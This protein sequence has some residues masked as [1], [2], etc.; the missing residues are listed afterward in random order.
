MNL[1]ELKTEWAKDCVIVEEKLGD[2]A[3]MTPSLH[4]KYLNELITMKLKLTKCQ[5]D[6]AKMEVLKGRYFRGEIT[7]A[8]LQERGW[9]QWQYR[10]LKSDIDKLIQGDPEVRTLITK[11]QYIKTII[12][13]LESVMGEI[14]SRSFTIKACIDWVKFRAGS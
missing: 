2:A 6:L 11:E 9:P 14:K 5:M 10:T 7:T 1:E 3:S 13:F 12:Y 8:E 4:S